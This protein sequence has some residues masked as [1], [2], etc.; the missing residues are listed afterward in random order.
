VR[1][2]AAFSIGSD[3]MLHLAWQKALPV[4]G[5]TAP[6]VANGVLYVPGGGANKL[7]ALNATTGAQLWDSGATIT[8]KIFAEAIVVD[9]RVYA[10]SW[11]HML[12]AYGP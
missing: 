5:A 1:G 3:C 4:S 2:V 6:T 8:D 7:Y 9:G 10:V 11:D 12:H